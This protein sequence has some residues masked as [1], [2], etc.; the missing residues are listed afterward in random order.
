MLKRPP[1][2]HAH[3]NHM[4]ETTQQLPALPFLLDLAWVFTGWMGVGFQNSGAREVQK[5]SKQLVISTNLCSLVVGFTLL[6][7]YVTLLQ[8]S[9]TSPHTVKP[10]ACSQHISHYYIGTFWTFC[11]SAVTL[12]RSSCIISLM[13]TLVL[14]S[15]VVW[16]CYLSVGC[17]LRAV[18]PDQSC[19]TIVPSDW[20]ELVNQSW[21]AEPFNIWLRYSFPQLWPLWKWVL[22]SNKCSWA[23]LEDLEWGLTC[24][25]HAGYESGTF[26]VFLL[27]STMLGRSVVFKCMHPCWVLWCG[28]MECTVLGC[29][30]RQV[31]NGFQ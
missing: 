19:M 16:F 21:D 13:D 6:A 28:M 30:S 25:R 11:S 4:S 5:I 26:L 2:E 8:P 22:M 14:H 31:H 9:C 23:I 12:H 27:F 29:S 10:I 18:F 7:S 24:Q 17:C 15:V 3:E 20:H 1:H